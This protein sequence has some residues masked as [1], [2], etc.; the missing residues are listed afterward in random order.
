MDQELNQICRKTG[1]TYS[2]TGQC[3]LNNDSLTCPD[4]L[5]SI[6]DLFVSTI[7]VTGEGVLPAPTELER[8]KPSFSLT[9]S[10]VQKLTRKHYCKV[11]G[12]LGV[13]GTGK[14]ASLVSLYL[15]L[16]HDK[17]KS[18]RFLDSK[19]LM[20]FEEISKGSRSWNQG[21]LPQQ[22]TMHTE[23]QDE[24]IAGYLHLRLKHIEDDKKI[25]FLLTDLPGEWTTT[26]LESNRTDR[27]DFLKSSDRIWLTI[28]AEELH[29]RKT[30]QVVLHKL[31][32]LVDR[33][34]S[35]LTHKV[36]DIT[37]VLTHCDKVTSVIE[38][39][40]YIQNKGDSFSIKIVPIASFSGN[41]AIEPGFGINELI[42]DAYTMRNVGKDEF[43]PELP[44]NESQ[45]YMIK[46]QNDR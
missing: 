2:Q 8:L 26:L 16:A 32:I 28:N 4:R 42:S 25:D 22:L 7:D 24:R 30:R 36:P 18:F 27:L 21:N 45:R 15:L 35:Y 3:V 43:W 17:L 23:L 1:C 9:L 44:V 34:K 20:A 5:S 29:N 13:P 41:E 10:E 38:Y 46:Y 40:S 6:A 19:T 39:L 37:I 31:D 14:T 11:I 33:I 12:I